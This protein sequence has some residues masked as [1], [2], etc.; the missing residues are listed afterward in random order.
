M[1]LEQL[2]SRTLLATFTNSAAITLNEDTTVGVNTP[3]QA[4]TPY[5]SSIVVSGAVG[6][7][8]DLN[9]ILTGVNEVRASDLDILLVG[10][11]G[12]KFIVVSDAGGNTSAISNVTVTFDDQA[13]TI[14]GDSGSST[15]W[16]ARASRPFKL[17][18]PRSRSP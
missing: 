7:I 9:V 3:S 11:G 15:G 5:P 17:P 13:A 4:A 2:E 14:F 12:Q 8:T 16:G 6:T 10:P 18:F 1:R